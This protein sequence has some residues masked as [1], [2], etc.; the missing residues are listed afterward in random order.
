MG[1]TVAFLCHKYILYFVFCILVKHNV[2][3]GRGVG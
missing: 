2:D 3:V 1:S